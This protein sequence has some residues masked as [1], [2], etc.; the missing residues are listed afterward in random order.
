MR[1]SMIDD[2]FDQ[3]KVL[4]L[5]HRG[6]GAPENTLKAFDRAA[7]VG[8]DGIEFDIHLT[9]DGTF[10]VYHDF[11][12]KKIGV[13]RH[14]SS[15]TFN[16]VRKYDIKGEPIPTLEEVVELCEKKRLFMNIEL[17]TPSAS[18]GKKLAQFLK[19][20]HLEEKVLV[21]S[22][23][24]QALE[25]LVSHS[26]KVAIG[27]LY[28]FPYRRGF[29]YAG[30]LPLFAVEP[31][32]MFSYPPKTFFNIL[33]Q[34]MQKNAVSSEEKKPT[35]TLSFLQ[36]KNRINRF[37]HL[38]MSSLRFISRMKK[39]NARL[40]LWTVNSAELA[41]LSVQLG[42]SFLITDK[43]QLLKHALRRRNR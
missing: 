25:N 2:L 28:T 43:V 10:V 11:T 32:F 7:E 17:K 39:K 21:S 6:S 18:A 15:M 19:D 40:G 1:V 42:A 30:K 5:A 33:S 9:T 41:L 16:E 13:P 14:L 34:I 4:I 38:I 23:Y 8:A 31:F 24:P 26:P 12:L 20:Y 36:N 37:Y 22:F 3:K 35:F 27:F 29:R